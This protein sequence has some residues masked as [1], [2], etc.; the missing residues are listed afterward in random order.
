MNSLVTST[1]VKLLEK[2][3]KNIVF[4]IAE[5]QWGSELRTSEYWK[6]VNSEL[7][8]VHF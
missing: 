5:L 6:H 7:L 3:T 2:N 8:I 1:D 4:G